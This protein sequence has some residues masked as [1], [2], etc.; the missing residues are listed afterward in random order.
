MTSVQIVS[1]L[2]LEIGRRITER[3]EYFFHLD[4]PITAPHLALL[5]DIGSTAHDAL[6]V[7]LE[8]Q[9]VG[10]QTMFFVQGNHG[11]RSYLRS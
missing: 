2:H 7:W 10:R 1:D 11:A 4:L 3:G 8:R 9:L 6:W 5:G